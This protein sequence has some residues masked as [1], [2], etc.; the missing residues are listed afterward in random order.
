MPILFLLGRHSYQHS[1]FDVI[2][3]VV[4]FL[5]GVLAWTFFEYAIHRWVYHGRIRNLKLRAFVESFHIYH[6]RNMED[7]RVITAGPLMI[8][9]LSAIILLP[10]W[11]LMGKSFGTFGIGFVSAYY[12]YEWVHF[13]IHRSDTEIAYIRYI[14]NYHL[15][16]HDHRWDRCFGN[17]SSLWDHLLGTYA[18][19][20]ENP[21]SEIAK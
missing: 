12:F 14:R 18:S 11:W 16:H 17:T 7:P 20:R 10:S 21:K 5:A 13:L 3:M 6:H 15:F 1:G 2:Q 19:P 9:P 8:L 4:S